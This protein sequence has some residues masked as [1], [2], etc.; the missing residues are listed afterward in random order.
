[1]RVQP[2]DQLEYEHRPAL[3]RAELSP[4]AGAGGVDEP[5]LGKRFLSRAA[6]VEEEATEVGRRAPAAGLGDVRD[7]RQGSPDQL[8]PSR[9]GTGAAKC[10]RQASALFG[11]SFGNLRHEESAGIGTEYHA[12]RVVWGVLRSV[13]I[14]SP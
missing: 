13:I 6:R 12:P 14:L 11:H 8:I 9:E 2:I 5:K 3:E 1:M 7:H 4:L 10:L